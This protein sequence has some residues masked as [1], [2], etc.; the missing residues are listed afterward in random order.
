MRKKF[1]AILVFTIALLGFGH[2][3][4]S[5]VKAQNLQDFSLKSFQADYYLSKDDRNISRLKVTEKIVAEFPIYDQ[6]HGIERAIPQKY[7]NNSLDLKISSIKKADGN[8]WNYTTYSQNDN[9]ILRIG[10][11]DRYVHGQQTYVINYTLR[12]VISFNSDFDEF[13]WDVNGDQWRQPVQSVEARLHLSKDIS[14]SIIKDPI[15]FTGYY[16]KSGKDCF[17]VENENK[18]ET[19]ITIKS[20]RPF[21]ASENMSFVIGFN[22][23]TFTK[24][25]PDLKKI[26]P[27]LMLMALS[28]LLPII[29][30]LILMYRKWKKTGKDPEGRRVIVPQYKPQIGINPLLADTILSEKLSTQAIS[31]TILDLCVRGYMKLYEIKKDKL[32]KDQT[33][34]ELE[35]LKSTEDLS[36]AEQKLISNIFINP[37]TGQ[38]VNLNDQK[39]KLY[40]A[41]ST[42]E[43]IINDEVVSLGYF[44]TSPAKA[45]K[46]FSGRA[47]LLIV[48][49][50]LICKIFIPWGVPL[51]VGFIASGL[52]IF[53][54]GA[55]MPSRTLKGV[56]AKEYLLGL[57]DYMN[58]A[59]KDRIKFLQSPETVEKIGV[60][61]NAKMI[62]LYEALLPYAI[63]FGME[64]EWAKQFADLYSQG[65]QPS[66]YSG[67]SAFNGLAL[68]S[69]LSNFNSVAASSFTAPSS[70]SGSGFSSGGGFSGGG[71]GGGGGGGW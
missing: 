54:F 33:E 42:I 7:K 71:G 32:F 13:Y 30:T 37:A 67:Q 68:S 50:F 25:S 48:A 39:N 69:A 46:M 45:R 31:A 62:K 15:C 64:K 11:A 28:C 22:K 3:L 40:S 2:V 26:L 20:S 27:I 24:W 60:T 14:S 61:D 19:V 8:D 43:K 36:E 29:F 35:L 53:A 23:G 34:Y 9:L 21:F 70:S 59:E 51:G 47:T 65:S 41:V 57:K 55:I 12:D 4:P 38:R 6:N 1:N 17:I 18:S 56:E 63:L 10:D 16:S 52:I 66:W 44:K 5:S 58:L 49:G